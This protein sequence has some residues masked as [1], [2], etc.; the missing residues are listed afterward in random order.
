[1]MRRSNEA[2]IVFRSVLSIDFSLCRILRLESQLP[3]EG[4]VQ[5]RLFQLVEHGDLSMVDPFKTL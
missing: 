2:F 1:M 5:H 4:A 3:A